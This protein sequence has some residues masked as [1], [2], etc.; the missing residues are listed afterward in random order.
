MAKDLI[1]IVMCRCYDT[2]DRLQM[3]MNLSKNNVNRPVIMVLGYLLCT[4]SQNVPIM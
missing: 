1:D 3:V 2:S 4:V